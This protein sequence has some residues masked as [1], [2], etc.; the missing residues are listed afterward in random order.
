MRIS[1]IQGFIGR[2]FGSLRTGAGRGLTASAAAVLTLSA[3]ARI[4]AALTADRVAV[5]GVLPVHGEMGGLNS[6]AAEHYID[7][8]TGPLY[9]VFLMF[10]RLFSPGG[11]LRTVFVIQGLA[12]V[13]CS[14]VA[15]LIALRLAGRAAAFA[16]LLLASFYPAWFVYSLVTLPVIFCVTLVFL[17]MLVLSADGTDGSGDL[18]KAVVSSVLGAASFLMYP[19]AIF[20]VPGLFAA[21]RRRLVAIS[22]FVIIVAPWGVRN[23]VV[24][25]RILPVYEPAAYGTANGPAANAGRGWRAVDR[26]YYNVSFLMKKSLERSHMPVFFHSRSTNSH[27]LEYA[28]VAVALLGLGGL[29]RYAGARQMR[30]LLPVISYVA[31][32]MLL[33]TWTRRHR[34]IIEPALLIYAGIAAA[35]LAGRLYSRPGAGAGGPRRAGGDAVTHRP[36]GD[37]EPF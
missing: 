4:W 7:A 9:P 5:L 1:G 27:F 22:V 25:G 17:I 26:L 32:S 24:E 14:A 13:L 15:F 20:L 30:M 16:A 12:V 29:I 34:T 8:S 28:F 21:L 36:K 19:P 37:R 31:L 23:S 33:V 10:I 6:M 18:P 11:G 35:G 3:A 2:A